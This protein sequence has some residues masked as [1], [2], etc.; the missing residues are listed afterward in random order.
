MQEQSII[1]GSE[2]WCELPDLGVPAIKVRVDSGAKTSA[3][4]A[5]NMKTFRKDYETWLSYELYPLQDNRST[6]VKCES[7]VID[8]RRV[9]STS[10]SS[11]SRYVIR[12]P[13]R[14]AGREWDIELTLTNRE[15]MGMRMLLGREAMSSGILVDPAASFL[16][17]DKT[18]E[19]LKELYRPIAKHNN[20]L[21][22]GLLATNPELYSNKRILEAGEQLG[23]EIEFFNIR[24]CYMKLDAVMPEVAYRGGRI[25][26]DLDAVI[27]RIRPSLT[28][29][30]CAL[31]RQFES[32]GVY[33]LNS[34][35]SISRS[36]DKLFSLQVMLKNGLEIPTTGFASGSAETDSLIEMVGG[37][38]L[39]IKLL[40]GTQGKGVVLA[41]T[42]QASESVI[43]AFQTLKANM[44]VQEFIQEA[45]GKDLRLF[46]VN[47]KVVAAMERAAAAGEFRA[48]VHMGAKTSKVKISPKERKIAVHAAKV[49]GLKVAGVD[50]IRSHKGPLV[51]E[52]NSSP[53]LQ[54]IE[55]VTDKDIAQTMIKAIEHNL[56]WKH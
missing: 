29:Y 32:I 39:I 34:A 14:I 38:P 19:Q 4:H 25:L 54:G 28:F 15:G 36:R 22:I 40:A 33:A 52:V 9:K 47:G 2:E 7:R 46:V 30:G 3:I 37:S 23:H 5:F 49:F 13:I 31:T 50:I 51:L 27:P 24:D 1:I 42:K 41:D 45:G 11:E 17:G 20:S 12:T 10:G 35:D 55:T 8:K 26:N 18:R 43:E 21:K 6:V 53:G 56:G 48:N 16:L 44:L